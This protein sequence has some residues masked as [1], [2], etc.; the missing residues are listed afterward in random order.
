MIRQLGCCRT[1]ICARKSCGAGIVDMLMS[2][3]VG[4]NATKE[5][6]GA[7]CIRMGTDGMWN[8]TVTALGVNVNENNH[9][10]QV[11]RDHRAA[12]ALQMDKAAAPMGKV[13]R[14]ARK[15]DGFMYHLRRSVA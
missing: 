3:T 4:E 2:M 7:T 5:L 6:I 12:L 9:M 13:H 14:R 15:A 10:R 1:V 11:R 8:P